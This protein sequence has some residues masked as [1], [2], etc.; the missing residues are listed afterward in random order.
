MPDRHS[1]LEK[2]QES[3]KAHRKPWRSC[4]CGFEN[5]N[6]LSVIFLVLLERYVFISNVDVGK[7]FTLV[8]IHT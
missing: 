5:V 3:L 1:S 8:F 6:L 7:A 2:E 4:I